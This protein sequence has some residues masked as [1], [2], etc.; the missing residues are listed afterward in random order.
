MAHYLIEVKGEIFSTGGVQYAQNWACLNRSHYNPNDGSNVY[1]FDKDTHT[2]NSNLIL[3][4]CLRAVP[5]ATYF[6]E[7]GIAVPM[8]NGD[9]FFCYP[10]FGAAVGYYKD[11]ISKISSQLKCEIPKEIEQTFFH[12]LFTDIFSILE[13]FLSD[14]IL[15][16]IYTNETIY[17]KAVLY[18][19][20]SDKASKKAKNEVSEIEKKVH[21]FFFNEIVYHKF[22]KV[23]DIYTQ[24]LDIRFPDTEGL[25][26]FLHKRNNIVH[27][28]SFSNIDRMKIIS[29]TKDTIGDLIK[30]M[31]LFVDRLIESVKNKYPEA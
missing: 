6:T 23:K 2:V 31:N 9:K 8:E 21:N 20:A 11:N 1:L 24:L 25:R 14:F 30:E 7:K 5:Y 15:C 18:Y 3:S 28:F 4:E 12:G 10:G 16:M 22:D 13:L 26:N 29:I 27:R 19:K 17:D